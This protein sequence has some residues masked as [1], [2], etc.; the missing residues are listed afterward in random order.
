M[1]AGLAYFPIPDVAVKADESWKHG[2][3]NDGSR[4]NLGVAYQF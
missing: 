2:A 4:I 3:D 1:T